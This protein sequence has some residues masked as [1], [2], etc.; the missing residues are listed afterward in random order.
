MNTME[1]QKPESAMK[2]RLKWAMLAYGALALLAGTTLDGNFRFF[3]WI[4]LGALA[5]KSWIAVQRDSED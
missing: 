4:V 3:V 1:I 2:R 5:L